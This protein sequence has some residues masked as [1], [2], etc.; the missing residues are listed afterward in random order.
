MLKNR[1]QSY[2][3]HVDGLRAIAVLSVLLYH[4]GIPGFGGGYVGVDIFFV[5]SG[6]LITRIIST[7]IEDTGNFSLKN[8]YSRRIHRILP[9]LLVVSV[10]TLIMAIVLFSPQDFMNFG[11]SLA[12]SS[13]SASNIFFWS[14][15]GYFDTSSHIKPLLHTWSLSVEEQF[16]LFWPM[17]VF[18]IWKVNSKIFRFTIILLIGAISFLFNYL[19]VS[20]GSPNFL[21]ELFFLVQFRIFE[22]ALGGIGIFYTKLPPRGRF[23]NELMTIIGFSLII[24]SIISLGPNSIFPYLNALPP[25]VGALLIILTGQK[26]TAGYILRNKLAIGIGLISYSLYLVHWPVVVFIEYALFALPRYEQVLWMTLITLISGC[27]LFYKVEEPFRKAPRESKKISLLIIISSSFFLFLIGISIFF[28]DGWSWRYQYFTPG[29][30]S[31][32]QASVESPPSE[33]TL[34]ASLNNDTKKLGS[35]GIDN[36]DKSKGDSS[37]VVDQPRKP[38]TADEIAAGK[39]KRFKDL[40]SSCN[41]LELEN[42]DRCHLDRPIQILVLGNSHEPDAFNIFNYMYG[43][44]KNINIISF[45]STNDCKIEFGEDGIKSSTDELGCKKRFQILNSQDFLNRVQ[46]IVYSSHT[47]FEQINAGHW[48]ILEYLKNRNKNI[49]II[50]LGSYLQTKGECASLYNRTGSYNACTSKE[51]TAYFNPNEKIS[52]PVPQ[53]KTLP[54]LYISKF[55]MLC[56]SDKVESCVNFANNEPMFYDEHHLSYGFAQHIGKLINKKFGAELQRLGL[57]SN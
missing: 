47:G 20:R 26:T 17:A 33:A 49:Q 12:A 23:L 5:I 57:T 45:G 55:S 44:N 8:F 4:F 38:L 46:F 51:F 32:S 15:S 37:V 48:K 35:S 56:T 50:A 16:Y 43:G 13:I 40:H 9:A 14:E 2:L 54:Y 53:V 34:E 19:A 42:A 41:M 25:C 39:S 7:E 22:F 10:V 27:L 31:T 30:I 52:S 6:F 3:S 28:S 29:K 1:N 18:L 21:S 36:L 24:Y 11:R